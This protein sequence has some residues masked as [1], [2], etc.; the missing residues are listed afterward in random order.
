MTLRILLAQPNAPTADIFSLIIATPH[1]P[2]LNFVYIP[3]PEIDRNRRRHNG[4]NWSFHY[5]S[6][7]GIAFYQVR[8]WVSLNNAFSEKT[9]GTTIT[10]ISIREWAPSCRFPVTCIQDRTMKLH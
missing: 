6:L 2:Q 3:R 5:S 1:L 8:L 9:A 7:R 4:A 10:N